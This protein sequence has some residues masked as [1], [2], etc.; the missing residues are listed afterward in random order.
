MVEL[1]II[2]PVYNE[3]SNIPELYQRLTA[4]LSQLPLTY[5]IIFINDGSTD[6][7]LTI[8]KELHAKDARIKTLS[9]SRNFGHQIA[10]SAGLD[11]AIGQAVLT[12]D[13]DLQDAPEDIP[14]FISKWKEGYDGVYATR[15]RRNESIIRTFFFKIFYRIF[16]S[17]SQISIPLDAGDF[18]LMDRKVINTLKRFP[19]RNRFLRGLRSWIGFRFT[20][21]PQDRPPRKMGSIKHGLKRLFH[22]GFDGIFSFS[23]TPLRMASL[24]GVFTSFG[25]FILGLKIVYEKFF[26]TRHMIGWTSLMVTIIFFSGLII[27]FLGLI[28]EYI[29]RI[30]DEIKQRPLYIIKEAIG[31]SPE[32]E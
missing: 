5:E 20:G 3:S 2:L 26:T 27:L 13:S 17:L 22:I 4:T 23:Y 8:L 21:I 24:V 32:D 14:K 1:S 10:L 30:Y 18:C 12:M 11:H 9:F 7:T 29:C 19:E 28:G 16:N 25:G 6:Q 15:I 31:V